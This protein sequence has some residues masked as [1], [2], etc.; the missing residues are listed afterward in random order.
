MTEEDVDSASQR[1]RRY[2]AEKVLEIWDNLQK[3]NLWK[4]ILKNVIATTLLGRHLCSTM[5]MCY[6]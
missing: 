1:G 4:R 6:T 3:N 5:L 2:V